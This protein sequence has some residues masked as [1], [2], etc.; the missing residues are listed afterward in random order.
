MPKAPKTETT[1]GVVPFDLPV[2]LALARPVTE[3]PPEAP[4]RWFEPKVDGWRCCLRT[5]RD[6]RLFSRHGTDLSQAF[7]DIV[8]AAAGLPDAVLDGELLAVRPDGTLAFGLLQTRAGGRGPR[9]R[10]G[11]Q[12]QIAAF[13][14]LAEGSRDLRALPLGERR[15]GLLAVLPAGGAI[16]PL[17]TTDSPDQAKGW[18]GSLGGG[19]EGCVVKSSARPYRGGHRSDWLKYRVKDS[20]SAVILGITPAATPASQSAVLGLPGSDGRLRAVGVSLPL[21]AALRAHLATRLR[22]TGRGLAELPGTVGGLPGSA[23]V[24]YQPVEPT[25]VV[26]IEVDAGQQ[27]YGR[28]R[29]RPRV[30]RL[31]ADLE[32]NDLAPR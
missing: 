5:G 15:A 13:D 18:F 14:L 10:E 29:H 27:E 8:A 32:A 25:T 20:V 22:P 23:P 24:R 17:P 9:P 26:D 30:L 3:V 11:F 12:T 28:Y 7:S 21:P 16:W 31:R 2:E 6:A 4:G 19:I 1:S